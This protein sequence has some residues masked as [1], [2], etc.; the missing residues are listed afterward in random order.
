MFCS[1]TVQIFHSNDT[2]WTSIA[3]TRNVRKLHI[4]LVWLNFLLIWNVLF[5]TWYSPNAAPSRCSSIYITHTDTTTS[6]TKYAKKHNEGNFPTARQ[7]KTTILI[8]I[9][10]FT[11]QF[12]AYTPDWRHTPEKRLNRTTYTH[13]NKKSKIKTKQKQTKHIKTLTIQRQRKETGSTETV[14]WL[15]RRALTACSMLSKT[16]FLFYFFQEKSTPHSNEL[17]VPLTAVTE[18]NPVQK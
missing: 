2:Q 6:L 16:N 14:T 5:S 3:S 18:Q 13:I 9:K 12:D 1:F 4:S 10:L 8:D 11:A 15:V 7:G 17:N